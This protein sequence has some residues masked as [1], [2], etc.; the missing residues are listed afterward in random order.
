MQ[1]K[2]EWMRVR[3]SSTAHLNKVNSLLKSY[4]LNTVCEAANCPN[5]LECFSSK[6]ATFMILGNECTRHCKFCNVTSNPPEA[7]SFEEP[8]NIAK[9]I[10]ELGLKHAVITSVTRDDLFDEGANHFFETVTAIKKLNPSISVEVLTPDFN[11]KKD[12]IKIVVDANPDVYNHNIETVRSLYAT[13]RP[14]ADYDQSLDVIRMI[15]EINPNMTTKSGI[16]LGL[17]ETKDEVIQ[18]LTDLRHVGCDIVTIGQ[19]MQPSEKHI[20]MVDYIHPDVFKEY[21]EL[22]YQL[23]FHAVASS[24]LVRS[25][26]KALESF[27]KV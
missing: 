1:R 23:G 24:P 14:E 7:V 16:M 11:G 20:K 12:L 26:Y 2:P 6:T 5:R 17:G 19:Y 8:I 15:K 9:A 18:T 4:N 22:S 10:K 25:S 13:V 3:L 27:Q 21:E